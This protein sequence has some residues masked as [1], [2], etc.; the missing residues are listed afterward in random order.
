VSTARRSHDT[1]VV[2][3]RRDVDAAPA[4]A[5]RWER[6][7][8][9]LAAAGDRIAAL[10]A[11]RRAIA[12]MP[13]EPALAVN[14]ARHGL[15]S[16]LEQD[17]LTLV[18]EACSRWPTNAV[19]WQLRGLL[20][21]ALDDLEPAMSALGRAAALAPADP[22][23]AHGYAR[24][25]L[26]AGRPALAEFDR[27]VSVAP[28]DGDL[29]LSRAAALMAERRHS[30]AIEQFA[31]LLRR[32]PGW[33]QGHAL[34]TRLRWMFGD[35]ETF[36]ASYEDALLQACGDV[37]LW[38]DY[39]MALMDAGQYQNALAVLGRA[40]A[41]A[42]EHLAFAANEA[43]CLSELGL[44]ADADRAFDG[45]ATIA[46]PLVKVRQVRH[47]LRSGRVEQA[48]AAA[49][50][51]TA[52]PAAHHFWPY[53]SICW[54]LL[55][56]ERWHWLEGDERFVSAIDL[57]LPSAALDRLAERLRTLHVTTGQ[58]LD[59]SVRGG[60]QTDGP[61][62]RRADPEVRE[63]RA[64]IVA[65]VER[66]VDALPLGDPTHPLLKWGG[67]PVRFTGSWSV[68]L[69]GAGHHANH[70]HP[71]GWL[72]SAFYVAIPDTD[73]A[74]PSPAGW[75]KLGE[76]QAELGLPIGPFRTI[77]PKPG[78][79]VLFPSTMWHGTVPFA[80]GERLTVAFD[81]AAPPAV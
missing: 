25:L 67:R 19:L 12:L 64:A 3:A 80:S 36:T 60:T 20:L 17:V 16:G 58:P 37:A 76:P 6:L 49:E 54:R 35:H 79:L 29:H 23:I 47:L 18:G 68:R 46:D 81:V 28:N 42:G 9:A 33:L 61:L 21:R 53:V 51:M 2:L 43:V 73:A 78:R 72:S 15:Q 31:L 70:V 41:A 77:E 65:A 22:K 34:I 48:L 32:S 69:T 44:V 26:E 71:A 57:E 63:L 75:L 10:G 4:D 40:R 14:A 56:D 30:Q 62:F 55:R 50:P 5:L 7:A 74:G 66:H 24:C 27:A 52:D 45:L 1:A 39:A 59:Q 8:E 13:D 11:Y 38:R